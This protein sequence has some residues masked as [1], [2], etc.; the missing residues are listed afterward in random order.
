MH[1]SFVFFWDVFFLGVFF[2][3]LYFFLSFANILHTSVLHVVS[4]FLTRAGE[5]NAFM[6]H[7]CPYTTHVEDTSAPVAY[8]ASA[9]PGDLVGT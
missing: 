9:E 1:L 8:P 3:H 2:I 4:K 7:P 5:G 6:T